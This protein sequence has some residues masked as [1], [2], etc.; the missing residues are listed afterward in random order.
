MEMSTFVHHSRHKN[1]SLVFI[2]H[3]MSKTWQNN[4]F[5]RTVI[6]NLSGCFVTTPTHSSS[7][8]LWEILSQ[9][10]DIERKKL[11]AIVAIAQSLS[12][13]PYVFISSKILGSDIYTRIQFKLFEQNGE[14]LKKERIVLFNKAGH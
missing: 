4:S 1:I 8:Q 10:I 13:Y 2:S 14:M 7:K 3:E 12:E 11:P 6:N 9:I 5:N